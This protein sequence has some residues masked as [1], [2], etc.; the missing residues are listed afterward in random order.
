MLIEGLWD[1]PL[2]YFVWTTAHTIPFIGGSQ[3]SLSVHYTFTK[4]GWI[5]MYILYVWQIMTTGST[6]VHV[7]TYVM[8]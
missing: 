4:N 7:M 1:I 5:E 6:I 2:S 3:D 8:N